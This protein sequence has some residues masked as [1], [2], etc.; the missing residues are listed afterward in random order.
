MAM[1]QIT[2]PIPIGD[3]KRQVA[4]ILADIQEEVEQRAN[5]DQ[6]ATLRLLKSL[7]EMRMAVEPPHLRLT[8]IRFEPL[9]NMCQ[10]MAIEMGLLEAVTKRKG[11][12]ITAGTLSKELGRPESLIGK[13]NDSFKVSKLKQASANHATFDSKWSLR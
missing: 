9:Q 3:G 2:N 10:L 1:Q 8:R 13:L 11:Q 4:S 6:T 5:G 7:D 12:S